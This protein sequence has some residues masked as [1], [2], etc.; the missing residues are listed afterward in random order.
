[1]DPSCVCLCNKLSSDVNRYE[2]GVEAGNGICRY[3]FDGP[4]GL[5]DIDRAN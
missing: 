2:Y 5:Q 1:M 4:A 3:V